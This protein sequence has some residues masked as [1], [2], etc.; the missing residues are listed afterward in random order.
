MTGL[1]KVSK[2]P[3]SLTSHDETVYRTA[4]SRVAGARLPN[5]VEPV[6]QSLLLGLQL[7]D[8]IWCG[9]RR[10]Q[11]VIYP[12]TISD[13]WI[14]WLFGGLDAIEDFA[15]AYSHVELTHYHPSLQIR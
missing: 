6:D 15:L 2:Y 14:D 3:N 12:K 5:F 9:S 8:R 13:F 11:L 7:P 10:A 1:R 4:S